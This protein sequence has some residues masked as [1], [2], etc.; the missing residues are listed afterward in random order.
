M[1]LDDYENYYLFNDAV[2]T[3][4]RLCILFELLSREY[5]LNYDM[6]LVVRKLKDTIR[7]G[8][9]LECCAGAE[10]FSP[11]SRISGKAIWKRRMPEAQYFLR[12]G[13]CR[14]L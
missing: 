13:Y 12:A 3:T 14:C 6:D 5:D 10:A 4:V 7:F 11:A 2:G 8:M 1:A 9:G